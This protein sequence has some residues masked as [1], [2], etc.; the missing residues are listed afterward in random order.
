MSDLEEYESGGEEDVM[1]EEVDEKERKRRSLKRR[2][3]ERTQAFWKNVNLSF[4]IFGNTMSVFLVL[5]F[6][7]AAIGGI[8][9]LVSPIEE[10][11][12]GGGGGEGGGGG[13]GGSD[14]VNWSV[15]KEAA[16]TAFRATWLAIKLWTR[17]VLAILVPASYRSFV[18]TKKGW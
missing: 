8:L 4:N 13:G 18:I 17:L 2:K 15:A 9:Q 14:E 11:G 16:I 1:E 5:F 3:R 7:T 12:G 10:K 6:S